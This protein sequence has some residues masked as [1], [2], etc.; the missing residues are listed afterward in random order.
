MFVPYIF[1]SVRLEF[2]TLYSFLKLNKW[3]KGF[4]SKNFYKEDIIVK[5]YISSL[6]IR[7][8]QIK[9]NLR[10]HLL[11]IRMD[12]IQKDKCWHGCLRSDWFIYCWCEYRWIVIMKNSLEGSK[13]MKNSTIIWPRN[14]SSAIYSKEMKSPS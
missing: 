4:I 8:M 2:S 13:N 5:K 11:L 3:A 12:I 7:E 9:T 6:T 1:N 14:L 10:Y